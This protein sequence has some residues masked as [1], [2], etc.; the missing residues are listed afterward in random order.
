[1]VRYF[2]RE[3][4]RAIAFASL[5]FTAGEAILPVIAVFTLALIGW[6]WT[7]GAAA[8]LIGLT[9]IP[10]VI[11]LLKHHDTVHSRSRKLS[12]TV[13]QTSQLAVRSWT[14]REVIR[15]YFFYLLMPGLLAVSMISTAL[16]FHHLN[17]ADEKSWSHTWITSNYSVYAAT[18][19]ATLIYS[20]TLIDRLSAIRIMPYLLT[21]LVL[22]MLTIGLVDSA[23][24]V[25]PYMLLLGIQSGFYFPVIS[26]L[27]AELYGVGHIGAIKS[28]SASAMVLSSAI[29]PVLMGSLADL[30]VPLSTVCLYFAA[31]TAAAAVL[32]VLALRIR[33]SQPVDVPRPSKTRA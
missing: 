21:P 10:T 30:G 16:F 22:A 23:W 25:V 33:K 32:V 19:C 7:Y 4:G 26:A 31:Y 20:G 9:V 2:D 15:D 29:G 6:R 18:T 24:G 8:V 17:L 5:G 27:W 13:T 12:R 11:W 28:L 1:M 14:R 3:R